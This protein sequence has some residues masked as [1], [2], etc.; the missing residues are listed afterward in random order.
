MEN[1]IIKKVGK[2]GK[3]IFANRNFKKG[4]HILNIIGNIIETENPKN[5]PEEIKEHWSP[6]G[7][8]GK[9]IQVY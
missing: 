8:K 6:L 9:K 4:E 7:K 1:V 3:G 2:K 5:Y